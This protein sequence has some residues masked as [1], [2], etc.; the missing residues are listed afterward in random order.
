MIWNPDMRAFAQRLKATGK[1]HKVV[2][3]AVK[4]KFIVLANVLLSQERSWTEPTPV[5]ASEPVA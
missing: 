1:A 4:R 5:T 3:V 2:V